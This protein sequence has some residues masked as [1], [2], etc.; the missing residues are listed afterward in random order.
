MSAYRKEIRTLIKTTKLSLVMLILI[1]IG[2]LTLVSAQTR[3]GSPEPQKVTQQELD[4]HF[5]L[6]RSLAEEKKY[7]QALKEYLYVFDNSRDV[8]GYGG[9]RICPMFQVKLLR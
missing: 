6:A 8:S 4:T 9:G 3:Q 1:S 7:E 5:E 2:C